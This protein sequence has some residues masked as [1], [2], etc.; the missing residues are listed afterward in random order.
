[1]NRL[2][3]KGFWQGTTRPKGGEGGGTVP[4]KKV[5]M[6]DIKKS[7][8]LGS[9]KNKLDLELRIKQIIENLFQRPCRFR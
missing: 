8:R 9:L 2:S 3:L 6:N 1:M 7:E 4:D 5:R